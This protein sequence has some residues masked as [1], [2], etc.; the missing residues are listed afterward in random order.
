MRFGIY[1]PNFGDYGDPVVLVDLAREAEAAGWD[2]FFLWDHLQYFEPRERV[3]VVDPWVA[4][5][6]IAASTSRVRLGPMVTPL[7][8]RR[9]WRLARETASL[10]RLSGGRLV[11]GVGL[12]DPAETDFAWFGEET[13]PR[14]RAAMLDEGLAVLAG[15]WSGEPFAHQGKYYRVRETT[16]WPPPLQSPRIPVWVGGAWPHRAPMRRAARWD[17]V[18]PMSAASGGMAMITPSELREIVALVRERRETAAPFAVVL[19]GETTGDEPATSGAIIEPYAQA[20]LTWWL[21]SL[22][23]YRG[24]LAAMRERIRQGPPRLG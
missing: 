2:G 13:D 24:P 22:H 17:G 9:P 18:F 11:L 23:G 3:A 15:L 1:V 21:E 4:L 19:A 7:A 16:F 5:S 12:G 10:D 8:R 14:V 6:A 20:G